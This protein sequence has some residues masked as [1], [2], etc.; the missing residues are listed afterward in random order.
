M[1]TLNNY[2][3]NTVYRYGN[4]KYF[5]ICIIKSLGALYMLPRILYDLKEVI[6][7]KLPIFKK[8]FAFNRYTRDQFIAYEASLIPAGSRVLDAG[9]G[10]CPYR[11]LFAHCNYIAQDFAK[12]SP[13]QLQGKK[14][15]G[16]LDIVCDINQL[17]IEDESID[18]VICTEVLEHIANPIDT[19]REFSRVLREGGAFAYRSFTIR[20]TSRALPLLWRIYALLV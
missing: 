10:T 3:E 17:P 18:V 20:V 9:A 1:V 13:D 5:K 7:L 8:I 15:Y 4:L 6:F 14:G 12:L 11:K 16:E 2:G 19:I